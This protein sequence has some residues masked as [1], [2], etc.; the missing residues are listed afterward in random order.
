MLQ[1][2]LAG[3]MSLSIFTTKFKTKD[4]G[5]IDK[6]NNRYRIPAAKISGFEA[7]GSDKLD[8]IMLRFKDGVFENPNDKGYIKVKLFADLA[9]DDA[10]DTGSINYLGT[11]NKL[12]NEKP[13][14]A[15]FDITSRAKKALSNRSSITI[16]LDGIEGKFSWSSVEMVIYAKS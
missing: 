5:F 6:E 11:F 3:E 8:R 16:V 2:D 4:K 1:I 13:T 10:L 7:I 12:P 14:V 15:I 9:S